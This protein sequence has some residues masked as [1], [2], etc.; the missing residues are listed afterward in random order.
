MFDNKVFIIAELSANHN[1]NFDTAVATI[2]AAAAAGA[3]AVKLQTYT[4]DTITLDCDNNYF[5][6]DHGTLWDGMTLYKLYEQAYTPWE[7]HAELMRVAREEGLVCFSSPFDATA[8]DF[9]EQLDVPAYKIASFEITDIPLIE[10]TASK[11][12]PVII[13]TGIATQEEIAEAVEACRRMGNDRVS[14]LKCTSAYPATI[15]EANLKT[16]A[17]M[18]ERF[19]VTVGLSDHSLGYIA[20]VAAVAMGARIVEKHLI[21]DRGMGGADS[22]FSMEPAEFRAMVDAIRD[23]E[24]AMGRV[25][26]DLSEKSKNNRKFARS[27]FVVADIAAGEKITADN[28]RSVRPADG[29]PPK[30][31][32]VVIGKR[33]AHDL[34]RGMPLKAED[35]EL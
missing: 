6:I 35:L 27:L 28:V 14:L 9:L 15:E 2:R 29:L 4:P 5:R 10:Y 1:H 7:W 17:D 23:V 18:K 26:Y 25:T 11:G 31:L 32:P 24:K 12:K 8:V 20:A 16:M 3:D 21:L 22:A 34:K 19:G 33:A 13:S 30:Y